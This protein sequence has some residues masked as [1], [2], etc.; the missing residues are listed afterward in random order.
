MTTHE[1]PVWKTCRM[2]ME[3]KS[4]AQESISSENERALCSKNID[5]PDA[6]YLGPFMPL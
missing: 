6:F 1:N 3:M 5:M 4:E 2:R